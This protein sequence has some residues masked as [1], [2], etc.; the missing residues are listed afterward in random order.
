MD[1]VNKYDKYLLMY[2]SNTTKDTYLEQVKLFLNFIESYK[3]RINLITLYNLDKKDIY[4]YIAFI[5]NFKKSTIKLKLSA[6]R[7]FLSF[8]NASNS[9]LLFKDIKL[10]NSDIK[11]PKSLTSCEIEQLLNYYMGEK[12]DIIF[13]FL[14]TG[15]RLTEMT[16]ISNINFEEKYFYVKAKGGYTR[17]V[18]FSESVKEVL[19]RLNTTKYNRR[20]I[21]SFISYA[22]KK[23]GIRGSVHTLRHTYA[24]FMYQRTKDILLVKELLGHKS[25]LSTQIYTHIDN[26]VI[27][28]AYE[29]NPLASFKVGGRR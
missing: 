8:I 10:F 26:D 15:L 4:N 19:L 23:L 5:S 12:R 27:K 1:I 9:D 25:V 6:I 16:Q 14:N 3:G 20:Q 17:K 29:S 11:L 2:Y 7:N 28:R 24:T 22:M 13:L 18:Y 21:Q